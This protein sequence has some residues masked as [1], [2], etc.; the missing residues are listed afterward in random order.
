MDMYDSGKRGRGRPKV[1]D[2][3][4]GKKEMKEYM[5]LFVY[6]FFIV[7]LSQNCTHN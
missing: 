4:A 3:G 7:V 6:L 2:K 5:Y 1:Y